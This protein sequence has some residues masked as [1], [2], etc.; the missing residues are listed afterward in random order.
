MKGLSAYVLIALNPEPLCWVQV[1]LPF[2]ASGFLLPL[3]PAL[4][5]LDVMFLPTVPVAVLI[6]E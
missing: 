2:L 3:L 5:K 1:W 6:P 4:V